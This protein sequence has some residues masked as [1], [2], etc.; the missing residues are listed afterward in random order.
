MGDKSP[1][2]T[3]RKRK[4]ATTAKSLKKAAAKAKAN[5]TPAL[6]FNKKGK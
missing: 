5:P 4:Q 1:R 2:S 6:Q 3:D